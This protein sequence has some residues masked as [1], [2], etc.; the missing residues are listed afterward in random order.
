MPN[1]TLTASD[2]PSGWTFLTGTVPIPD[3][4]APGPMRLVDSR[5][6]SWPTQYEQV[7]RDSYGNKRVLHV[8]ATAVTSGGTQRF[9]LE[10]GAASAAQAHPQLPEFRLEAPDH[11]G[12]IYSAS[13]RPPL[14]EGVSKRYRAA[15]EMMAGQERFLGYVAHV[16][17][18][19]G[20][21]DVALLDLLIQNGRVDG[22]ILGDLFFERLSL[23]APGW[24]LL[25]SPKTAWTTGGDLMARIPDGKCH[26]M[27]QGGLKVYR[28]ALYRNGAASTALS[29]LD[30]R[31]VLSVDNS[32]TAWSWRNPGSAWF[33][34]DAIGLPDADVP[35]FMP[36]GASGDQI[37]AAL[38]GGF[39]LQSAQV[40]APLGP[41][42]T[43]GA[44]YGGVTGGIGVQAFQGMTA[45]TP[46]QIRAL[47]FVQGMDCDRMSGLC[48]A[49]G[50]QGAIDPADWDLGGIKYAQLGKFNP[51]NEGPFPRSKA[52]QWRY[53][54]VVAQGRLPD[55]WGGL[56]QF[57]PYDFQHMIRGLGPNVALAWRTNDALAKEIIAHY[58][59]WSRIESLEYGFGRLAESLGQSAQ[60]PGKGGMG[61]REDGW[62]QQAIVAD[63]LLADTERRANTMAWAKAMSKQRPQAQL[64]S[65]GWQANVGGKPAQTLQGFM[66]AGTPAIAAGQAIEFGIDLNG[67]RACRVAW[68]DLFAPSM[69]AKAA[70]GCAEYH[71]Q[72]GGP[73]RIAAVRYADI[74]KP[75]FAK[76][77]D[78]PSGA[79]TPDWDTYQTYVVALYALLENPNDAYAR[80][81]LNR[82]GASTVGQLAPQMPEK[83]EE[84]AGAVLWFLQASSGY[85]PPPPVEPP[86]VEPPPTQPPP[87]HGDLADRIRA[88][89]ASGR[90]TPTMAQRLRAVWAV[91]T[92]GAR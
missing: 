66:P 3:V 85:V 82:L 42:T 20:Q 25:H 45:R 24:N 81:I 62:M 75:A 40:N 31:G 47:M 88:I 29:L 17:T 23:S 39:A 86:P 8:T 77:S 72:G 65:G 87:T 73:A 84:G 51:N 26:G 38:E 9:S 41:Y 19:G 13:F 57:D 80:E 7:S 2:L 63:Y 71:W 53:E 79:F 37:K 46:E 4:A 18:F 61:G 68:P 36:F 30:R 74:T 58:S 16:T 60:Y 76:P 10:F 91:L 1:A 83:M 69:F 15:G 90:L 49:D 6:V 59:A 48:L 32:A 5:G 55:Y 54:Q 22:E 21:P 14:G 44:T 43:R 92:G 64:P 34:P 11:R 35:W 56:V 28:I 27:R 89:L 33:G 67:L 70:K 50:S 12:V 52:S 78:A